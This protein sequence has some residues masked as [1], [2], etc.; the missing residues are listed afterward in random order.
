MYVSFIVCLMACAALVL[1]DE[2][3]P[4]PL[5]AGNA[6][7]LVTERGETPQLVFQPLFVLHQ[8]RLTLRS[9]SE[10]GWLMT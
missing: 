10:P 9:G 3:P 1:D 8:V 6:A 4:L 2:T 7:A 5:A